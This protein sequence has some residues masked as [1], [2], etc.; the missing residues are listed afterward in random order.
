M[1]IIYN[2]DRTSDVVLHEQI[3]GAIKPINNTWMTYIIKA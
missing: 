2:S 3:S 1:N